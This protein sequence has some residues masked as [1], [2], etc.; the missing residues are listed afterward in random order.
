MTGKERIYI[1]NNYRHKT[2]IEIAKYLEKNPKSIYEF[3]RRRKLH[4]NRR[5]TENEEY[6]LNN[7]TVDAAK[8]FIPNKSL[9]ALKLKQWRLKRNTRAK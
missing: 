3:L 5:Y 1:L 9:N 4:K 7:F 8:E 6:L 2:I